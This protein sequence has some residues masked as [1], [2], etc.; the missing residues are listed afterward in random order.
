MATAN[1]ITALEK[2]LTGKRLTKAD[3]VALVKCASEVRGVVAQ[4]EELVLH[5]MES[6]VKYAGL[7]LGVRRT[8][9]RWVPKSRGF[10]A[11]EKMIGRKNL[12]RE[13]PRTMGDV[14][15]IIMRRKGVTNARADQIIHAACEKPTGAAT[16]VVV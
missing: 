6:G 16:I 2:A 9:Y 15:K 7:E 8:N 13:V 3:R 10:T 14:K 1:L 11:I 4:A 12:W 5:E